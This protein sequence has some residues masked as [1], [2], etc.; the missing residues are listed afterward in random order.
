M[1]EYRYWVISI[2]AITQSA[3]KNDKMP[4][5]VVRTPAGVFFVNPETMELEKIE[6]AKK[7]TVSQRDIEIQRLKDILA[8]MKLIIREA[9]SNIANNTKYV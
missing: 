4:W 1:F 7:N 9:S 2:F 3:E 8:P 6:D 5:S